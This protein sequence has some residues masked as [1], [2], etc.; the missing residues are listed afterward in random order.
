MLAS[1]VWLLLHVDI[2]AL[3]QL[4][5]GNEQRSPLVVSVFL[6]YELYVAH[7]LVVARQDHCVY[8][9]SLSS[10]FGVFEHQPL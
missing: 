3:H 2:E 8:V 7:V 5:V 9:P 4:F 6:L 1:A 10:H